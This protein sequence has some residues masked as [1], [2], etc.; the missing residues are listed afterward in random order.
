M[1]LMETE[2]AILELIYGLVIPDGVWPTYRTVDLHM[3]RELNIADTQA[4]LLAIP[5]G[6]LVHPWRGA[7]FSDND[8]IRL[9]LQG[10]DACEGGRADIDAFASFLRWVCERELERPIDES[11]VVV[12]SRQYADFLGQDLGPVPDPQQPHLMPAGPEEVAAPVQ[13]AREEMMRL[14]ILGGLVSGFWRGAGHQPDRPWDWTFTVD[15][16]RL[17]AYRG[18]QDGADL[19]ARE[20]ERQPH[21]TL[22]AALPLPVAEA[23]G[24]VQSVEATDQVTVTGSAEVVLLPGRGSDPLLAVLR[25]DVAELCA[26]ALIDGRFDDAIFTAFR[27]VEAEVQRRTGLVDVI[28]GRLLAAAFVEDGPRQIKVSRRTGDQQRLH[29]MFDGAIGLHR[30]DRAHK[31]KPSLVCRTRS[32][33][34]RVLAHACVLLDL[35][36]RDMA[37]APAVLGYS[38]GDDTLTLRVERATP[39]TRVLIDEQKCQVLRRDQAAVTISTAGIPTGEHEVVL[40]DGNLQSPGTPIW[41]VRAPGSANWHRVEEIDIPLFADEACTQPLNATGLRLATREAGI[42]GQRIVPTTRRYEPGDYVSWQW[43]RGT[44]LPP[45]WSRERRGETAYVAFDSSMLFDGDPTTAAHPVRTM[46]VS[47]E[48]P[49]LK[50]RVGEAVPIRALA[51]KTDGTATWADPIEDPRIRTDDKKIASYEK[52]SLRVNQPGRC[53][54]RFEH[55]GQYAEA[56]VEAAAHPRGTVAD[57]LTALPPVSDLAWTKAAGLLLTTGEAIIWQ[58]DGVKGRFEPAAGL[59]LKPPFYGGCSTLVAAPN[60]DL[61]V[62]LLDQP[63]ILVLTA[64]TK[65]ATSYMIPRPEPEGTVTGFAWQGTDL[66]IAMNSRTLWRVGSN[67]TTTALGQTPETILRLALEHA[68]SSTLIAL[69]NLDQQQLWR[70]D[71]AQPDQPTNLLTETMPRTLS[72]VATSKNGA[73]YATDFAGGRLLRLDDQGGLVPVVEGLRSPTAV[74]THDDG[75]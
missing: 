7:S 61:A 24:F 53:T 2:R 5:G 48:P 3:D 33:C 55:E 11:D 31:D 75:T 18:L 41:L 69:P 72:A 20:A 49:Y 57:W 25:E 44:V 30:G 50:A 68:T 36:D 60:G 4:A 6:L 1:A 19:L 27:H 38:Q 34:L 21:G 59:V 8:E 47:L 39:A 17:R 56:V 22:T 52:Q 42:H 74:A 64:A 58:V 67:G 43:D 37:V 62:S 73:I 65:Y 13:A 12:T 14:R 29:Q 45:A 70:I 66:I 32:E 35:L 26:A 23:S 10:V 51:W 16:R 71:P 40:I 9:T 63:D 15:R 46:R 28:G 54:L